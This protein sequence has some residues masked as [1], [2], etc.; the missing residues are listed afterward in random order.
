M[1]RATTGKIAFVLSFLL[2]AATAAIPAHPVQTTETGQVAAKSDPKALL[3]LVG[4]TYRNLKRYHFDFTLLTEI[5]SGGGRKSVETNIDLTSIR[6]DRL[7]MLISGGL[8]ELQVYSDGA[9]AWV[10]VPPLKQYTRKTASDAKAATTDGSSRFAAIAMQV[11][12]QFERISASVH[13]AKILRKERVEVGDTPVECLVVEVELEERDPEEKRMR[14]YWIDSQRNLVLKVVQ[15][16]KLSGEAANAVE[17]EITTTF[18]KADIDPSIPEG[19]FAFVPP[20]D[21]R[22]VTAFRT[23]R[24]SAIEIGSEAADFRLKD[25]EGREIQLKSLRGN[26]V[27]LNFW[28]TWCGPCR[29]EMPVIENL[30]Q[31]FHGKGLRVFGVNDE[32]IDTIREYVAEHEYS[33]PTLVDTDQQAMNLYRIRGIPTMVVID[34]EGKIVQYRLGLSRESDLRSWLKKAGIE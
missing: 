23:S 33:F 21:A 9:F 31:Q 12:E 15:L 13:T 4:E 11:F 14:T 26:V 1:K 2:I 10:F 22:E 6:P 29:L 25:L 5:R 8:G 27:L 30:H 19:T 34:R 20:E 28:A 16:D 32:E 7:R 3:E 24:S 17:T 18:R